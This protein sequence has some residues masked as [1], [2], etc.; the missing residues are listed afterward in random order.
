MEYMGVLHEGPDDE[1]TAETTGNAYA[2]TARFPVLR[3]F[4]RRGVKTES[5]ED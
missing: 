4:M 1:G 2:C 3:K 5:E